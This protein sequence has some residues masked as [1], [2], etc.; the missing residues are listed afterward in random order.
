MAGPDALEAELAIWKAIVASSL[1]PLLAIDATGVVRA[2]SDSVE[3]VFGWQPAELVGRNVS[4]LMPEP[5]HTAHDGYLAAYLRTGTTH[6][7]GRTRQFEVVRKDGSRIVCDLSVSRADLPGG[8]VLFAGSFRDVTDRCRAEQRLAES[9]RRFHAVFDGAFQYLGLLQPDGTI[10]EANKTSLD[11]VGA[12]RAAVVGLKFWE[13]PWW[14]SSEA[15]RQRIREAVERAR[16]GEFVRFEYEVRARSGGTREVDF[17]LKPVR[18]GAG[19]VILLIPEG[20]DVTELKRAQRAE[21]D[22]LRRL[23]IVGEQAAVLAHEIK[24]P[25][26]AVNVALRAVAQQLGTDQRTVLEDLVT[27]MQRLEQLLRGTLGFVKPV[28]LEPED[29]DAREF[30]DAVVGRLRLQI[31]RAGAEVVVRSEP[32]GLRFRGDPRRLEEVLA[33]LILNAIEAQCNRV[34][35]EVAAGPLAQGGVRIAVDDDGP[36]IPPEHLPKLFQPFSTTKHKGTGLG[37]AI[38]KKIV[39]AH[40]GALTACSSRLGGARFEIDLPQNRVR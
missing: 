23:A 28:T 10:L 21:T 20:R 35:I 1:D 39:E 33:N 27:R 19:T 16:G 34:H 32:E 40:G 25:I 2:A 29:L 22:M 3:R 24:N 14:S 6:I 13:A 12:E 9:E 18:D 15:E 8:G 11:A 36:G 30:L 31:V 37:L 17:S 38:S 26:T 5:H 4:V 7:L